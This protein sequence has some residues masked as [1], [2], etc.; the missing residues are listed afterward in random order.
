MENIRVKL[1]TEFLTE[2]E[3][4]FVFAMYINGK[5]SRVLTFDLSDGDSKL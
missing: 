3:S 5:F 4:Q 1:Q 2:Y